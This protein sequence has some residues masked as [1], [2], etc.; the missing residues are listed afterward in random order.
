MRAS[1]IAIL[2][3]AACNWVGVKGSGTARSEVRSVGAF[4][5][6]D[7]SGS[8]DAE[9]TVGAE[10]RVEI[11]GDDN[12][13]PLVETKLDGQRLSVRITKR[14]RPSLPLK[15]RIATARLGALEVAGSSDVVFHGAHEDKLALTLAGSTTVRGDGA[16]HELEVDAA[17]SCDVELGQLA[18]ERVKISIS[19]SGDAVVAV[20]QALDVTISGSG[21]VTYRGEPAITKHIS[22]S[23]EIKKQ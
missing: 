18:A 8:I 20:S 19:G 2:A 14:V 11:T 4:T 6:V 9:I 16:A 1:L 22:G 7:I 17:G 13:V 15:A 12:L 23:G 5:A 10:S 3:L 21:S